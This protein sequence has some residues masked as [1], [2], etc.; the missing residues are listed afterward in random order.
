[1]SI[2]ALKRNSKRYQD[3]ISGRG[4]DGFS[5]VGGHRNIGSVGPTNL[6]KSVTR[7]PFRG[8]A[9][10]GHGG[11]CGTYK[12]SICNSGS[13]CTN[14]PNIIKPTVKNNKGAIL[15][16]YKWIHSAY[17]RFWVKPDDSMPKNYSQGVYVQKVS[18]QYSNFVVNKVN[19]GINN[20]GGNIQCKAA[21]YYIGGKKFYRSVYSKD[22]NTRPTSCSQYTSSGLWKKNNLPTPPCLQPFPMNLSHNGCDTNYLTPQ[23]A[24]R[25]GVLPSDWMNCNPATNPNCVP[26]SGTEN[27]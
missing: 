11:C 4:H 9:P 3:P 2:V 18:A 14:D 26:P 15:K 13:C 8:N 23:E 6:A 1:M 10:M 7:T 16:Q 27:I 17:P 5:L 22:L 12:I 25:D 20:C 24:I 19:T 21:S